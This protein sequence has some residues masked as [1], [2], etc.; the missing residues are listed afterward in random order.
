MRKNIIKKKEAGIARQIH[1]TGQHI[2]HPRPD[3]IKQFSL[4]SAIRFEFGH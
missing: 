2:S 4:Y 3:T 1:D